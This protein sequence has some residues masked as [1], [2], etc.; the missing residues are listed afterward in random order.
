MGSVLEVRSLAKTFVR[1]SHGRLERLW[2]VNDVTFSV[3]EGEIF[4]LVGESGCGKSTI[5]RCVLRLHPSDRG[6]ITF[7][8]KDITELSPR[9]F[10]P[11][12]RR[13]NMVFQDP[14]DSLN[15][16]MTV[17]VTVLEPLILHTS[18]ARKEAEERVLSMLQ[19][20][21]LNREH[22]DRY[23]H[24]LS[25]G[26]RQRVGIARAMVSS[27]ELVLLDE[28]TAALDVSVRGRILELLLSLRE[29][30]S[31][32]YVL[33]SHDLGLV[34]HVCGRTAVMYLGG[35]VE[36]GASAELLDRPF[37]PYTKALIAAIPR[38]DPALAGRRSLL[39]GEVPSPVNLP[40]GCPFQ[41]RCQEALEVC[42]SAKP[43]LIP[44]GSS[45]WVACHR[46]QS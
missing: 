6:V 11:Y 1:R 14:T 21:G 7:R 42:K 12:R 31:A 40:P 9:Q 5:A 44:V 29:R 35:L 18:L 34:R 41:A 46:A 13:I 2:A 22:L 3:S 30:L 8:G 37:H 25:T 26:Q 36:I 4:G 32:S 24:Q 38:L 43:S 27:P 10:R 19:L 33:I 16:R 23:P 39:R 17:K 20:V 45:R 15:P 28:P